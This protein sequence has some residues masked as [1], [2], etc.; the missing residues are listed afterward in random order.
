[1]SVL[2]HLEKAN[3]VEDA[4]ICMTMSSVSHVKEENKELVKDVH[5]LARWGRCH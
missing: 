3:V 4:L 2:Y 1:M 5:M